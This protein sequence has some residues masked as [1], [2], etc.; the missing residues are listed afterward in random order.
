MKLMIKAAKPKD[1]ITTR[2]DGSFNIHR[3]IATIAKM[4]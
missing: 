1:D 4:I 2:R 3:M